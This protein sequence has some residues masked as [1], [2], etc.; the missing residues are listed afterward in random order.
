MSVVRDRYL[1]IEI[2]YKALRQF[3][4][5]DT[6]AISL[7]RSMPFTVHIVIGA[8][9][10]CIGGFAPSPYWSPI[11]IV[12]SFRAA[13]GDTRTAP[14][15]IRVYAHIYIRGNTI[16]SSGVSAETLAYFSEYHLRHWPS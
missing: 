12:C 9:G 10:A 16:V 15:V 2:F 1:S 5:T 6:P 4:Y 13:V 7:P 11:C 14:D 3:S 8:A